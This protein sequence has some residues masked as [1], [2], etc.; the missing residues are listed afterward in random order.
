VQGATARDYED[1]IIRCNAILA[2]AY[3]VR[4]YDPD[5]ADEIES[6]AYDREEELGYLD[7]IKRGEI[8][9][10]HETDFSK[11]KGIVNP[12]T[13]GGSST[14]TIVNVE[15]TPS[16]TDR[17]KIIIA[18][19][20]TMAYGTENTSITFSTYVKNDKG[21]KTELN[22]TTEA[23]NGDLQSVGHGMFIQFSMGVYTTNDEWELEISSEHPETGL[24]KNVDGIRYPYKG[25]SIS[26][27]SA[28]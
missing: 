1:I 19:G 16:S 15:G 28:Y 26:G 3:L 2:C 13:Y 24:S 4:P 6:Q 20:G 10:W 27:V 11:K 14:G 5:R 22:V 12:V 7:K 18:N 21:Y 25:R 8:R 17:I 9:M 23:I